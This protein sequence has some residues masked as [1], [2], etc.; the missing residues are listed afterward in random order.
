MLGALRQKTGGLLAPVLAHIVAD[1]S[2]A[3]IV[4]AIARLG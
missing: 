2:I 4:I 1:A 3:G